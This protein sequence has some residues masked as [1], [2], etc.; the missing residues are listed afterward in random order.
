MKE[1][2]VRKKKD[3]PPHK[4]PSIGNR[5]LTRLPRRDLQQ[6]LPKLERVSLGLRD[7]L[8]RPEK[9]IDHVYFVEDG[10]VSLVSGLADGSA[11]EV[12]TVGNEGMV[13][14]PVF[15][16]ATSSPLRA[17]AQVP[18]QA[19]KLKTSDFRREVENG[20][21][22]RYAINRY[23]QALFTQLSQS[24]A[25]NRRHPVEQRCARWLLTTADRVT[26]KRF[27]LTQE[28]LAQML[29]IR[30]ASVNPVLQKFQKEQMLRYSMGEMEIT[31]RRKL[32]SVACECYQIIRNEYEKLG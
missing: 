23:A 3:R 2:A 31:N 25:C 6:L 22:L 17:F 32:E 26:D 14:L 8:Y 4:L 10:V 28:F 21:A 20:N 15:F 1:K 19:L 5:L 11:V 9:P 12:G 16:G 30:R 24:V 13:G 29:G 27:K 7:V 18:G